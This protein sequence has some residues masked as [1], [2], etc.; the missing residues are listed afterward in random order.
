MDRLKYLFLLVAI[1]SILNG[2]ESIE[3]LLGDYAQK[4]DLSNQT[5]KESAGFVQ[6]YTRQDL[7]RMKIHQL[8]ELIEKVP[9]FRYKEDQYGLT[10]PFYEPYQPSVPN[11]VKVYINDRAVTGVFTNDGLRIFGQM[12]MAFVDH[13]EIYFGMPSQSFGIDGAYYVIKL[14]TKDPARENTT[15]LGVAGGSYNTVSLYGYQATIVDDISYLAYGSYTDFGRDEITADNGNVLKRDKKYFSTY[16]EI[17]KGKHRIEFQVLTGKSD[18]FMGDS[19]DLKSIDPYF[20]F[21]YFYGG[22]YYDDTDNGWKVFANFTYTTSDY[23]D[24]TNPP[25]PLGYYAL[26]NPPYIGVYYKDESKFDEL[27]S[28]MQVKKIFERE[29]FKSETGIQARYK[30][31]IFEDRP[32]PVLGDYDTQ[33]LL[34]FFNESSYMLNPNHIITASF[35]IDRCID[36]GGIE[37][38]TLLSGRIGYIYN[39]QNWTSKTFAMYTDAVP[40]MKTYYTN[41]YYFHH[42]DD[43]DIEHGYGIATQLI[44]RP[45]KKNT[46]SF[47]ASRIYRDNA[48]YLA[49]D[50]EQKPYYG[51][52]AE[53]MAF[54]T[55]MLEYKYFFSPLTKISANIW[56]SVNHYN[57]NIKSD[58][59][60]GGLLSFVSTWNRFDFYSD[61]VYKD[62][63]SVKDPGFDLNLALTYHYSRVFTLFVKGNNILGKALK[64]DYYTYNPITQVKT[65][66]P[67]VDVIDRRIWVGM[68]YQF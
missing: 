29:S 23:H 56:E 14:Y 39:N 66:L 37:D 53:K 42:N 43:P 10:S 11:G 28:D 24:R 55:F 16:G 1:V 17:R 3:N 48:L 6:V 63:A 67:D 49:F 15:L 32:F 5:T 8:L 60:Y 61:L 26:E 21:N 57:N 54:T 33:W 38:K 19:P 22:W 58:D 52:L 2:E 65:T 12:D 34:S 59:T 4:A 64:E 47:I 41:R 18:A 9:F 46:V 30:H 44:Y 7:D 68:E 35:K 27:F 25:D 36:N 13:V 31:F 50:D 20:D 62:Y 40:V 51:N 45:N